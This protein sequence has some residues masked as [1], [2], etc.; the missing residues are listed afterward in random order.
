MQ[1]YEQELMPVKACTYELID[2]VVEM[3]TSIAEQK[4]RITCGF[5]KD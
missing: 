4:I 2:A 3:A 5:T 1:R